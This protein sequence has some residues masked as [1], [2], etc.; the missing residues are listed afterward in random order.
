MSGQEQGTGEKVV[1][2]GESGV[3]KTC[4]IARFIKG[5][6]VEGVSSTAASYASKTIDIPELGESITFDIWDTAGQEK[7]RSLTKFF[8]KGA[9]MAILV[10]DITRK[11]SFEN[12][13]TCWYHD[14]KE[15]GDP[16]II[17]GI[18]GNKCDLYEYEDVSEKE[19]R[20]FA[21]SIDAVFYLTSAQSNTGITELFE[22]LGKKYLGQN[23]QTVQAGAKDQGKNPGKKQEPKQEQKQNIKIGKKDVI[24]KNEEQKK[25]KSSC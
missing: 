18:A 24:K 8:F 9:K 23:S 15:H 3:G 16:D 10:Y 19:A 2:I 21:K 6:Y 11:E 13:K 25:K 7:Y 5:I 22:D 12:L 4:I 20:E 1:F 14:I 17:L